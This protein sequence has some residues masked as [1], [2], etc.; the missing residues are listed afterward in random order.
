M[1]DY[2]RS[3]R[4]CPFSQLRPEISAAIRAHAQQHELGDVEREAVLCCETAN[5]KTK[6][7]GLLSRLAGGDPDPVHYVGVVLTP[8]HLIW[9]RSG[10]KYSMAV[11]SARLGDVEM[12]DY[13]NTPAYRLVPDSGLEVLGVFTGGIERAQAFIGF[14]PEPAAEN[15]KSRLKE[16]I[17]HNAV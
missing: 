12:E 10:A 15:V 17:H 11:M 6:K 3:T 13:E 9:A 14:G 5:E 7:S 1:G 4:E 8:R 2:Q 16:A